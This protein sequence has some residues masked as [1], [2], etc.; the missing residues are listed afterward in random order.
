MKVV[1]VR[2]PIN[3]VTATTT[4]AAQNIE[5]A[6]KVTFMFTRSNHTAGSTAFT[7]T[8]S[9]D[10]VTYVA[11]NKLI[12]NV[13]NT[14]VQ[15]ITRVASVTL[16]ANSSKIYSLDLDHDAFQF[17]KI[18]ATETTDGTHTAKMLVEYDA[19]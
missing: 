16:S 6:K 5:G 19:D 14:N 3:G 15:D 2:T 12:D 10:G 13:A 11:L 4:S 17:I 9:I 8:G 7:V 18:T 1:E